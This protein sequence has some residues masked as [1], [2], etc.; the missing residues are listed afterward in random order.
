[1][2]KERKWPSRPIERDRRGR[3]KEISEKR[4]TSDVCLP[5]S[6]CICP[7]TP[8]FQGGPFQSPSPPSRGGNAGHVLIG[9]LPPGVIAIFSWNIGYWLVQWTLYLGSSF[10]FP[11]FFFKGSPYITT[12]YVATPG[13][14]L[15]DDIM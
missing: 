11:V 14:I 2:N 3:P 1:M 7:A 5:V 8:G 13:A 10:F 15:L 6:H 4:H 9:A 12:S